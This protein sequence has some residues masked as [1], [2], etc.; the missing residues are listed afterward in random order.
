MQ[1]L[2]CSLACS[3]ESAEVISPALHL[4][5]ASHTGLSSGWPNLS[6]GCMGTV[7]REDMDHLLR[8]F[9]LAL[10]L[11]PQSIDHI[12]VILHRS[13]NHSVFRRVAP[14]HCD[15]YPGVGWGCQ[16][17]PWV[18]DASYDPASPLPAASD[19][20]ATSC[21]GDSPSVAAQPGGLKD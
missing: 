7:V 8:V 6:T 9:V 5:S 2:L 10:W 17:F 21:Q 4:S 3:L 18:K 15:S 11:S 14:P 19:L 13:K 16:S 12:C 1:H 20:C